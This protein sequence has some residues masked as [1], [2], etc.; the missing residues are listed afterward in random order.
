VPHIPRRPPKTRLGPADSVK[1]ANS[2]R[3]HPIWKSVSPLHTRKQLRFVEWPRA[4][5]GRSVA[6]TH[7]RLRV[8]WPLLSCVRLVKGSIF[9]YIFIFPYILITVNCYFYYHYWF[10]FSSLFVFSVFTRNMMFTETRGECMRIPA[11][12]YVILYIATQT[13]RRDRYKIWLWEK[14]SKPLKYTVAPRN[15]ITANASYNN[16]IIL[17]CIPPTRHYN[18]GSYTVINF[19]LNHIRNKDDVFIGSSN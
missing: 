7:L 11:N 13:R 15:T 16:I 2:S 18:G 10:F 3:A 1:W 5:S 17:K 14:T 9:I 19:S 6:W 12:P 8:C 4:P